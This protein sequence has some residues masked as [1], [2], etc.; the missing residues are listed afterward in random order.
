MGLYEIIYRK[1]TLNKD[2]DE[3]DKKE[4]SSR[5]HGTN[6]W[7]AEKTFWLTINRSVYNE[8]IQIVSTTEVIEV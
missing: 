2:G 1:S 5:V 4:L 6:V 3:V 8:R 7:D